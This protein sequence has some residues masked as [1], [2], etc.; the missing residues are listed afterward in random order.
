MDEIYLR[1]DATGL[2]ALIAAGEVT[3][4]TDATTAVSRTRLLASIP[5]DLLGRPA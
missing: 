2:A 1:H 4:Q 3:A 5:G